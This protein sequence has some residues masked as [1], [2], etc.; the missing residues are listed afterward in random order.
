MKMNGFEIQHPALY[1]QRTLYQQ[2]INSLEHLEDASLC[3]PGWGGTPSPTPLQPG[4]T[5]TAL[6]MHYAVFQKE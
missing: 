4:E 6:P 5:S 1:S 3:P 2:Y